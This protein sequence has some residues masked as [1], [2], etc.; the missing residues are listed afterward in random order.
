MDRRILFIGITIA[1]L[2]PDVN[3]QVQ[4]PQD[5]RIVDQ[6]KAVKV[7]IK[8]L[9][10][11]GG[12]VPV[13]IDPAQNTVQITPDASSTPIPVDVV[14][15]PSGSRDYRFA[16]L[17]ATSFF[18]GAG[19]YAMNSEC[20]NNF[21]PEARMCY[22]EEVQG[23]PPDGSAPQSAGWLNPRIVSVL[24]DDTNPNN[25]H[26]VLIDSSGFV[27][28][29]HDTIPNANCIAWQQ[30]NSGFIGMTWNGWFNFVPCNT[31]QRV[32]CCQPK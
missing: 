29:D 21:G 9:D 16:G 30:G 25:T 6:T 32:A 24:L 12:T 8:G 28:F 13:G 4:T 18:G 19:W 20:K 7:K 26:F 27:I 17:S 15:S 31:E 23:S 14:S 3:A 2:A 10:T 11:S 1:V 22:S 5:V